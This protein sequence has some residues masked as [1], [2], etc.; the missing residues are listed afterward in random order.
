MADLQREL[1]RKSGNCATDQ[2]TGAMG[3][4]AAMGGI[5]GATGSGFSA[6]P[7]LAAPPAFSAP[8]YP[9][10]TLGK[11]TPIPSASDTSEKITPVPNV[12]KGPSTYTD[13]QGSWTSLNMGSAAA[14]TEKKKK[15]DMIKQLM[16]LMK[17]YSEQGDPNNDKERIRIIIKQLQSCNSETDCNKIM[18]GAKDKTDNINTGTVGDVVQ[19]NKTSNNNRDSGRKENKRNTN[20]TPQ[21]CVDEEGITGCPNTGPPR[22]PNGYTRL[23]GQHKNIS[24]APEVVQGY[25]GEREAHVY[26]CGMLCNDRVECKS[27]SFDRTGGKCLLHKTS[28]AN[29]DNKTEYRAHTFCTKD[30]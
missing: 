12:T 14:A 21:K 7:A 26:E 8:Q 17:T 15:N 25:S 6:P 10:S 19:N 27:F 22:C 23:V 4:M 11:P 28:D 2:S 13:A 20:Q 18:R 16:A 1:D 30:A 29:V 3:A 5:A 24:S 9:G